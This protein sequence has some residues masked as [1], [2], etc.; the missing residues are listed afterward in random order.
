MGSVQ[1][2]ATVEQE[3][4]DRLKRASTATLTMVLLK[5]GIRRTW[6]RG[7]VPVLP[8]APRVAGAAFTVRFVPAREDLATP[9]S[10]AQA[11][12]FRDAVEA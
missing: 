2:V 8:D 4:I 1:H 11:D 12:S 5:R 9:A 10:Y 7:P 6:M 3:V